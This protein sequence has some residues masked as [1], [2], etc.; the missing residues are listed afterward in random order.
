[1]PGRWREQELFVLLQ[2]LP[3]SLRLGCLP[4]QKSS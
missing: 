3:K 4:V 1:V 2:S